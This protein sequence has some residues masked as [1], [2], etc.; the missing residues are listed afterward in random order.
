MFF[1]GAF[2]KIIRDEIKERA[3]QAS[4]LSGEDN[5]PLVC[6]HIRHRGKNINKR[7]NYA[8]NGKLVTDI[9]HLAHHRLFRKATKLI[10]LSGEQNLMSII[11]LTRDVRIFN[12]ENNINHYETQLAYE[13]AIKDWVSLLDNDHRILGL[14]KK[15]NEEALSTFIGTVT[16]EDEERGVCIEDIFSAP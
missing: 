7:F 6:A 13:N 14:T 11:S 10:G 4:E 15:D 9:E 1:C 16:V 2:T 5:R 3:N 12:D 8:E